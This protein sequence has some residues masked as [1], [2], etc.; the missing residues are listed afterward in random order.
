MRT[1]L[2]R[3]SA[4]LRL[5]RCSGGCGALGFGKLRGRPTRSG[6]PDC[7]EAGN[8]PSL[9]VCCTRSKL[10][11]YRAFFNKSARLRMSLLLAS[12]ITK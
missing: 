10:H 12:P 7:I 1:C 6:L 9:R 8:N 5:K 2:R 3:W 11:F 4:S